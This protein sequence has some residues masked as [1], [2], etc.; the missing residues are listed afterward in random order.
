M[1]QCWIWLQGKFFYPEMGEAEIV[2]EPVGKLGKGG[3]K[4][5]KRIHIRASSDMEIITSNQGKFWEIIDKAN[6]KNW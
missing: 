2:I 5:R 6:L 3:G 1:P 4:S